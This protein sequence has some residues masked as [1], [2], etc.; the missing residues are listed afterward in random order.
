MIH[1]AVLQGL[2]A[3]IVDVEVGLRPG[4]GFQIV[5]LG[6]SAVKES[7]ERLRHAIRASGFEWPAAAITIN[8][9]PADIPKEGTT[10]DL[11]LAI[12]ILYATGQTKPIN[13]S[14]YLFGELGLEG[15]LRRSR[16]AL[17]IARKIPDGSTLI[18]PASNRL[19]LALLRH[20]K[21]AQ[22]IF[23]PYIAKNLAE[24]VEILEGRSE[25]RA[26]AK[27]EEFKAA[28]RP[29]VD[30][31]KV[32]GQRRAKRALEV[33]A[34]GGHNVLLIGPPGEGKSLLAKALPT[35]IPSLSPEEIIELTDIYSAKD[36]LPDENS[37]VAHRPFRSVHHTAS[38]QSIVGGGSGYPLPGE[39]T[40][41]HRGILFLDELPE[42][43]HQ[44]LELLRQPLEDGNIH[45]T[46]K[47]GAATYPCEFILVAAMNPCPCD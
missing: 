4:N 12:A 44:L 30:F 41:A 43:G 16:G 38:A 7:C 8:L 37:V 6:K 1:G 28:F 36:A 24:V 22:K 10:L 11:A 20:L 35:I 46:R 39:I 21:E 14:S 33:A 40:L 26:T 47:D 19:E 15:N 2:Q 23:N 17:S 5:G 45:L 34:A 25:P 3:L 42:F 27:A 13:N 9:A 29:G 32:K 31:K 18:A